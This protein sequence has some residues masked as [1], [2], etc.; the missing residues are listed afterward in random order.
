MATAREVD[1]RLLRAWREAQERTLPATVLAQAGGLS[2]EELD[3]RLA[4]LRKAGYTME[5]PW[6]P[7]DRY[8]LLAGPERLIAD[9]LR[10]ARPEQA[11]VGREILVFEET[12]STN[13]LAARAGDDGVR[14]GLAIFAE[15][16]RAG[17]G[18][19]G[20]KW[21]SP[22]GRNLL[23]S[24]LLRPA[25]VPIERWPELTFC[26]ALA[27]AETAERFTGMSAR[28]KWPNDVLLAGR[29]VAGILLECHQSQTPGFVV[30]G[31]GL[32]V[33]QQ[34]EDFA[35][36]LRDRAGSLAML[37]TGGKNVPDLE[38]R[39]V[40]ACLLER[41]ETH[42]AQWP[43]HF[44]RTREQCGDRGCVAPPESATSLATKSAVPS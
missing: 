26:A 36:E 5:G 17:R 11:V 16:Q 9:D 41:L 13:D 38:R 42:Y 33:L 21:V 44:E 8:C 23:C 31:I 18:R 3:D 1:V 6:Q 19:L 32:N 28:I 29:K 2:L 15:S 12:D 39:T 24:V 7:G 22:P 27:V 30:V 20:R 25:A 4:G 35:P 14:E 40:A 34:E 10:A 37:R 43:G